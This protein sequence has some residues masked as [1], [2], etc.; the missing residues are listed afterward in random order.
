MWRAPSPCVR[1][2][3]V[4]G[5]KPIDVR[6]AYEVVG[7]LTPGSGREGM[8]KVPR[9]VT[10]IWPWMGN[11]GTREV[12]EMEDQLVAPGSEAPEFTLPNHKGEPV[13]LADYRGQKVVLYF[14]GKADTPG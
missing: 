14:F 8:L 2:A 5:V 11:A 13:S 9:P 12:L 4:A 7:V 10:G 6:L 1:L 3:H